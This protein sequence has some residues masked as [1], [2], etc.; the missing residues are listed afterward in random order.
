[1]SF[2]MR[3]LARVVAR[4]RWFS[5]ILWA[6]DRMRIKRKTDNRP[7]FPFLQKRG[8]AH[9]LILYYHRV[10]DDGD[11]FFGGIPVRTFARQMEIL[12]RFFHL[13]PLQELV[14]RAVQEDLPPKAMAL[15][16]DDGYRDNYLNAFP[17]L[18]ELRL[19]ATIF[20]ATGA[21]DSQGPLWHD[22]IFRAF[23]RTRRLSLP[24][25]GGEYALRGLQ[26]KRLSLQAVLNHLRKLSPGERDAVIENVLQVLEVPE[27]KEDG[28]DK[29]NWQDVEEMARN[30]ITFGAH[31][32][33][34]PILTRL[35]LAEAAKEI[36]SS[37]E[38]IE[39]KLHLP[40]RLFS[41]PNGSREDFNESIKEILR[42]AGF[43]GA[44]TTIWG[45]NDAHTDPFE[46]RRMGL[47]DLEPQSGA[48][49]LAWYKFSS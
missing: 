9:Y 17:I 48:L 30:G 11:P 3:L 23:S 25:Q 5:A 44:L 41:Y 38:T 24:F 4:S 47:W 46:F 13:L 33:T 49:K 14:E 15:T 6:A 27:S 20:L 34:H 21:L 19:P 36:L 22:R 10:N 42:E 32:V 45:P 8:D 12:Q 40:V 16:F 26:E 18:K 43:V 29:L 1:M 28:M 31:T 35:P 37:K 2:L 7:A 39:N